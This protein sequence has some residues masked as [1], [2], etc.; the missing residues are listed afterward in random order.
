[1]AHRRD[2]QP[3]AASK[4]DPAAYAMSDLR[5]LDPSSEHKI[6][7]AEG[8]HM[9][10]M[11]QAALDE[12]LSLPTSEQTHPIALH[13]KCRALLGLRLIPE[14]FEATEAFMKVQPN[15]PFGYTLKADLL[16]FVAK[17][18]EA[19]DLLK[20]TFSR[21]PDHRS[22]PYNLALAAARLQLWP[23]AR[24]WIYLAITRFQWNKQLAL[25]S[26]VLAPIYDY[27][28]TIHSST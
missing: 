10:G 15:H 20:T 17:Y 22:L 12:I 19:Y 13:I 14:T 7:A 3:K 8:Y 9:M 4:L 2:P 25:T 11:Y 6:D 26:D 24:H 23:E 28:E 18:R 16:T 1:M 21:F 5:Q 27:I